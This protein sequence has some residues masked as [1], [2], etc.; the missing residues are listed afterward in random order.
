MK[1]LNVIKD[2]PLKEWCSIMVYQETKAFR[3]GGKP[4]FIERG[5]ITGKP[6]EYMCQLEERALEVGRSL[7]GDTLLFVNTMV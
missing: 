2:F 6:G 3:D 7:K 4:D 1:T 5:L